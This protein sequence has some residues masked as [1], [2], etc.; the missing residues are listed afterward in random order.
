VERGKTGK[1]VEFILDSQIT[2]AL[3]FHFLNLS[4]ISRRAPAYLSSISYPPR[5]LSINA[6]RN[7]R[8]NHKHPI[9]AV[10]TTL[11]YQA[12]SPIPCAQIAAYLALTPFRQRRRRSY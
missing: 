1:G 5:F 10:L 2:S 12:V 3:S 8:L 4:P 7:R 9:T 11:R 6:L